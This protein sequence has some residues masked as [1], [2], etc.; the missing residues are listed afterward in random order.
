MKPDGP[1]LAL[2]ASTLRASAALVDASGRVLGRWDQQPGARGTAALAA[3]AAALLDQHGVTPADLCGV[4]VGTGPG[5]YTGLR[6][7]IALARGLALGAGLPVAGV[8][9]VAAAALA[10]CAE[11]PDAERLLVLVDARRGEFYRADYAP[12]GAGS[13]RELE[14][15]RL[16]AEADAETPLDAHSVVVLRE[17]RPEARHLAALAAQGLRDGGDVPDSV[18]PLYLKRSHAEI[19]LDKR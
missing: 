7:S 6:A 8:P 11:H 15:P 14:P 9:S 18:V 4:A 17:P 1:I 10:A 5:S 13:L 2:E 3:A 19:Q 16:V 12:D